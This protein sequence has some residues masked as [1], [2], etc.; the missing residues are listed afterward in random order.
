MNPPIQPQDSKLARLFF[1]LSGAG[2]QTLEECPSWERRKYV[3]FGATVLVPTLFAFVA[4]T[5]CVST[6]TDNWGVIL[7]IALLWAFIILTVDRALLATYRAYQ[8][9]FRKG[10]QLGLR[11]VVA[12]LM[13]LTISHPL[14][15]LLFRDTVRTV[16]EQD[17]ATEM[18]AVQAATSAA[19]QEVE[20]RIAANDLE[21][22]A[23]RAKWDETFQAKFLLETTTTT[24]AGG[25]GGPD[26]T[27][28]E[29]RVAEST[30]A[31][32]EKL[33]GLEQEITTISGQAAA[34]Q[35]ELDYW[36]KEYERELN[37]QR[38]GLVGRGPR[39]M[40]IES[41]QLA[42][43]REES[44]RQTGLLAALTTQATALRNEIAGT[45]QTLS[46]QAEAAAQEAAVKAR[47]EQERIAAL[48]RQVQ[49]AQA[50]SF[51]EQQNV[52]RE[53]LKEQ[54]DTR[55]AQSRALQD[56]LAGLTLGGQMRIEAIAAEPRR[57]IL[58]QT[59][60]L[61][62]LFLNGA[63]GG[64][65]ALAAYG[66]LTLLFLLVDTIPLVVKFFSKPGPYD[67]LVD[68]DEIRFDKERE[69]FLKSYRKYMDELS[70]GR[71]LHLTRNK[72]LETAL[73]EGV[74]RSRAAKEFLEHLLELEHTFNG[75]IAQE[76]ASMSEAEQASGKAAMLEELAEAFYADLRRRMEAFFGPQ[77]S[78][79]L[80]QLSS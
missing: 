13:G 15:L 74:D 77:P 33:D 34:T 16:I 39:A 7:P 55:I 14:T 64:T 40:S 42:W 19:K 57:D 59:L 54:I 71:L 28:L 73:I 3:A 21:I 49:Q 45:E 29:K 32:R 38:S 78:E 53:T 52:Y 65:F 12:G 47:T 8:G 75:R 79:N 36:Q 48:R 31:A 24:A 23:Q 9:L 46:A 25:A 2:E 61:H 6:L 41:D 44:Q 56:E 51:V 67:T 27:E 37:G 63:Q 26:Q 20:A 68:C 70:N 18:A 76:R 35:T 60:A 5:Y 72:P 62:K 11:L 1:W 43:R 50:D 66:I 69:T 4:A 17:R 30:A 10:A 80:P 22:A 58:T